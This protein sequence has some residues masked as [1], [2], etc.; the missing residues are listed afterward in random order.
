MLHTC[1]QVEFWILQWNF[2][3]EGMINL[4]KMKSSSAR[5]ELQSLETKEGIGHI[6]NQNCFH[7]WFKSLNWKFSLLCEDKKYEVDLYGDFYYT[8][9][10][11][12][13]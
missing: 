1:T 7:I 3:K 11:F 2:L 8:N 4:A 9:N 13:L 6:Q 10:C 5:A 12:R